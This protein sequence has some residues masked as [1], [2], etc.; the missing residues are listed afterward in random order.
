M[1]D[2]QKKHLMGHLKYWTRGEPSECGLRVALLLSEWQGLHHMDSRQMEKVD[3][4]NPRFQIVKLYKGMSPGALATYDFSDLTTL[5][6][7]AHDHCIRVQ[8]GPCNNQYLELV[9]HPREQREGGMSE[10][11]PTLEEAVERRRKDRA[12]KQQPQMAAIAAR[13]EHDQA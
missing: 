9:F 4:I 12:A 6:F 13:N 5:V 1:T 7:L 3:W 8:I 11:H 10:R 2:D